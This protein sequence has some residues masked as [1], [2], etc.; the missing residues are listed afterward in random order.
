MPG[1]RQ[2]NLPPALRRSV[3]YSG[4]IV[5]VLL[6]QRDP[7]A[8]IDWPLT[9]VRVG[10][11]THFVALID[12]GWLHEKTSDPSKDEIA[13]AFKAGLAVVPVTVRGA[14]L[15]AET[16]LPESVRKLAG[17]KALDLREDAWAADVG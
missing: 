15:F 13:L 8:T 14:R 5:G 1:R 12:P 10:C 11:S 9:F 2:S 6:T 16:N 17:A 7:A 4:R 3:C